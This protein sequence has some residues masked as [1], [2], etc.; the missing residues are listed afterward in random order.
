M[1][2]RKIVLIVEDAQD[3]QFLLRKL[4]IRRG[5]DVTCA[6]N[7]QEA[8]LALEHL[9]TM[10]RRVDLILLDLMM[11]VMDG[12][13]FRAWQ[14][15]DPYFA[16]T[17]LIVMTADINAAADDVRLAAKCLLRK[18][19]DAGELISAVKGF[20]GNSDGERHAAAQNEGR[21]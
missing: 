15:S 16:G 7:G 6:S 12:F 19:L 17:A 14:R 8:V 18:P 10:G 11:P 21:N 20:C 13:A 9:R 1:S 3:V 5:L 2:E 4:L